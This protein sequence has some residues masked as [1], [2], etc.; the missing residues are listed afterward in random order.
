M[1]YRLFKGMARVRPGQA[2]ARPL[3]SVRDVPRGYRVKRDFACTFAEGCCCPCTGGTAGVA[4]DSSPFQL[5]TE[6]NSEV[7]EAAADALKGRKDLE[8]TQAVL[9]LICDPEP[10]V[11]AYAARALGKWPGPKVTAALLRLL[12]DGNSDVRKA[13]AAALK[14]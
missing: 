4:G 1:T 10:Q 6:S 7:R 11:G 3:I 14:D 2:P 12:T 9:G 13:A 5:L 8:V